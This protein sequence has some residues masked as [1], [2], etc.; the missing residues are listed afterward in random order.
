MMGV[1]IPAPSEGREEGATECTQAWAGRCRTQRMYETASDWRRPK[2]G[3]GMCD[4][5]VAESRG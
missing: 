1:R 3:C 4:V 2:D 5:R